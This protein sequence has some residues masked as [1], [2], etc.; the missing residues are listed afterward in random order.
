MNRLLIDDVKNLY[1]LPFLYMVLTVVIAML[2]CSHMFIMDI[3]VKISPTQHIDGYEL[4]FEYMYFAIISLT[5]VG[6]GEYHPTE[7]GGR[8]LA[9]S[10]ALVGTAHMITFISFTFGNLIDK[11]P[12]IKEKINFF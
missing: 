6:Y 2:Y 4:M 10:M 8:W 9:I 7:I 11:K 3:H 5:S 1:L 12:G